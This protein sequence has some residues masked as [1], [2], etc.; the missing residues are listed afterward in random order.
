MYFKHLD[1]N[2]ENKKY[3]LN[4]VITIQNDLEASIFRYLF[5]YEEL[6]VKFDKKTKIN[7]QSLKPK[8]P[9][10]TLKRNFKDDNISVFFK[11]TFTLLEYKPYI[12]KR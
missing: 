12:R 3:N 4:D 10:T 6:E 1:Q 8:Q 11:D 2:L 7:L 9:K 5:Y